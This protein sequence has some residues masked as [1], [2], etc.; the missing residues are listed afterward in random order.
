MCNPARIGPVPGVTSPQSLRIAIEE[1]GQGDLAD[2]PR[3]AV[4]TRDIGRVFQ[5]D[6]FALVEWP[7]NLLSSGRIAALS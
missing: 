5:A 1:N 7:E 6:A 3:S 4:D 2:H